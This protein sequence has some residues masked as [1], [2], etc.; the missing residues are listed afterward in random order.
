MPFYLAWIYRKGYRTNFFFDSLHFCLIFLHL[1]SKIWRCRDWTEKRI[2]YVVLFCKSRLS[3]MASTKTNKIKKR[4]P[5]LMTSFFRYKTLLLG[6]KRFNCSKAPKIALCLCWAWLSFLIIHQM[7]NVLS[8]KMINYQLVPSD[9][10][11][12]PKKLTCS[13]FFVLELLAFFPTVIVFLYFAN[14]DTR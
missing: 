3:K 10:S 6:P 14:P 2:L 9:T 13:Q 7:C 12:N 5:L 1:I 4:T 11:M 8:L